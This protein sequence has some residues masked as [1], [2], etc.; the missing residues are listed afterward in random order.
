MVLLVIALVLSLLADGGFIYWIYVAGPTPWLCF[1]GVVLWF[2][3][4]VLLFGVWV[5]ILIVW[6]PF[7]SK[8]KET[9]KPSKFYYGVIRQTLQWFF[10][11]TR[12]HVHLRG[13]PLPNVPYLMI[14]NHRSNFDQMA[15]IAKLKTMLI[16]ITKPE[17][18]DFPIAGPFIHHAGFIPINREN[19][20]EGIEAIHKGSSYLE[21][22]YCN[23]GV[24]PE[25]TRNKTEELLLP[26][27]PGSFHI[28]TDIGAPIA[29][30]CIKNADKVHKQAIIK[31]T[32]IFI[33]VLLVADREKYE[34]M[35]LNEFVT[36]AESITRRDLEEGDMF[37]DLKYD[38]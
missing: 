31:R 18:F 38:N 3:V 34:S 16:C 37:L 11:L 26:Y 4:F 28:A 12:I 13:E 35:G 25:G 36:Y 6:G 15:I 29:V 32:D 24:A 33:D 27:K 21:K 14:M 7:L 22:G 23:M 8:K 5:I 1:L 10:K 20:A 19:M 30:V 17:N 2:P 9:T